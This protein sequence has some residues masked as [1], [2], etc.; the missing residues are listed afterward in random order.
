MKE[1]AHIAVLGCAIAL[2]LVTVTEN[3][4]QSR[5]CGEL[6][7]GAEGLADDV[8]YCVT[9]SADGNYTRWT[10]TGSQGAPPNLPTTEDGYYEDCAHGSGLGFGYDAP[11]DKNCSNA[12]AWGIYAIEISVPG[13]GSVQSFTLDLRDADWSHPSY[14]Q[15]TRIIWQFSQDRVIYR[16][17]DG[18][19]EGTIGSSESI[20]SWYGTSQNKTDLLVPVTATTNFC[21]IPPAMEAG[22]CGQI[23]MDGVTYDAPKTLNWGWTTS[24]T[25]TTFSYLYIG[26]KKYFFQRWDDGST[27]LTRNLTIDDQHSSYSYTAI[28]SSLALSLE[29]PNDLEQSRIV[30]SADNAS[31]HGLRKALLQAAGPSAAKDFALFPNHPNPFN[32]TT[33]IQYQLAEDSKVSLSIYTLLGEEV[34][35]LVDENQSAGAHRVQ[36]DASDRDG[37]KVAS[38]IYIYKLE[39]VG[40]S[41]R[42]V[43]SRKMILMK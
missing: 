3:F 38:G 42:F 27:Q 30:P 19:H 22:T 7:F 17:A 11:D 9:I 20:W 40:S 25:I 28:Y 35:R 10:G 6:I 8:T 36:W 41:H 23:K 26:G 24:H 31:V 16:S 2:L 34:I 12:L 33:T 5:I 21:G 1:F 14:N 18:L 15:D 39:A 13:G 37:R 43:Q 4:A 32:P 29:E